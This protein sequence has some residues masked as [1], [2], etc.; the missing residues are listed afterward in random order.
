MLIFL[1]TG[2]NT[3]N[4]NQQTK[5]I[6]DTQ[7]V[8]IPQIKSLNVPASIQSISINDDSCA[9]LLWIPQN[10]KS[11][12]SAVTTWLEQAA[13][14]AYYIEDK[15]GLINVQYIQDVLVFNNTG[16]QTYIKSSRLYNWLKNDEW[17]TEFIRK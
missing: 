6:T 11:V 2:C 4:V 13:S 3:L 7:Q 12:S 14:P 10:Q 17:K 15:N 9:S 8:S 16:A 1:I 5:L